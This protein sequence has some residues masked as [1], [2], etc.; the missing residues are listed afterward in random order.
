MGTTLSRARRRGFTL[1]ELLVVIMLLLVLAG[2]SIAVIIGLTDNARAPRGASQLQQ[3][4]SAAKMRAVRD[5]APRGVRLLVDPSNPMVV[6]KLQY[7]AQP[8]DFI[9]QP[10]VA[11]AYTL[12]NGQKQPHAF[13][14]I[15][16]K[17]VDVGGGVMK[18]L[19]VLEPPDFAV[20]TNPPDF[21]GGHTDPRVWPVQAGDYLEVNGVGMPLRIKAVAAG[22][23][24]LE[25]PVTQPIPLTANYRVQ[26]GPRVT[27]EDPVELP[28]DIV[29]DLQTNTDYKNPLP[30][31]VQIDPV[32]KVPLA[33]L[34]IMF[35]PAG[36]VLGRGTNVDT[37]YLWVRDETLKL[38]D[39]DNTIVAIHT[40]TGAVAAHPADRSGDPYSFTKDGRGSGL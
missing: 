19:A 13:R 4:L 8:E 5:R 6:R 22:S 12:P 39:G 35:S 24:E 1:I 37:I 30:I 18:P 29:I 11:V 21:S 34:D 15:E 33:N 7:I 26:R 25:T 17:M 38:F 28:L 9:V 16:V 32:T 20:T 23:L 14:R 40:R 27:G 31:D 36:S 10:G 2:L 3:S